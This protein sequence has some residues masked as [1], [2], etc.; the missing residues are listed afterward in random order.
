MIVVALNGGVGNQ[1]FQ[2][3]A[4]RAL[5]LRLGV[6]VGL[7]RR[8]YDGRRSRQYALDRFAIEAAPV[9]PAA[10]PFR[11]GKI[12]G[13]LLSG[14]GGRM[15]VYRE[16]GL[17]FDPRLTELPDGTYLRGVFQS[18]RYFADREETIR[19]DLAFVDPPDAGTL[20]VLGEI[21]ESLAVSLHVRRGD[22]V[23]DAKIASV[24]GTVA[25][26]YYAR[27]AELIAARAGGEP[28]IFVFSDDPAWVAE[29]LKL[30]FPLRIVAHNG[31]ERATEDVRLMAACRHHILAN[32]SF[33]WW[34][35]WLN[36]SA[37]KI[38]VAPDPWF[39]DPA[40][41]DSTLVPDHWIRLPA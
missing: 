32:S 31:G 2:Y 21:G 33:S 39:R 16:T 24:H 41:D 18:E 19:R 35:A 26:D 37:G 6:P 22:Y 23:A 11:D 29:N 14:F 15:R 8:W 3:A 1:L 12:L 30:G 13:R 25:L 20:A 4:A 38:V 34:G 40:L 36:P 7:D 9:D 17:A 27:A 28:R 10:L 5:A